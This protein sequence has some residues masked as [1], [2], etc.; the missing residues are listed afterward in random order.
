VPTRVQA[1]AAVSSIGQDLPGAGLPPFQASIRSETME[2][3]HYLAYT[4]GV[5][6]QDDVVKRPELAHA[7]SLPQPW[8]LG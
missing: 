7:G 6:A 5:V 3:K 4:F 1:D 2:Q 8:K